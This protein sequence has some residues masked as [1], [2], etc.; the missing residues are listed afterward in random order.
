[1]SDDDLGPDGFEIFR[2]YRA[3]REPTR[4]TRDVL[5]FDVP[6]QASTDLNVPMVTFAPFPDAVAPDDDRPTVLRPCG[7]CAELVVLHPFVDDVTRRIVCPLCM[8]ERLARA[9][10]LSDDLVSRMLD[11][12]REIRRVDPAG[13]SREVLRLAV[14][15]GVARV[16]P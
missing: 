4:R 10:S 7:D 6:V 12:L 1:M 2:G 8:A 16:S 13:V 3:A 11:A 15:G 14:L 5:G 9:A